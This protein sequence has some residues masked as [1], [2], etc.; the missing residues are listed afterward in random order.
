M[1]TA[2]RAIAIIMIAQAGI[3]PVVNFVLIRPVMTPP[4]FLINAATHAA[5][6]RLAA[7][8]WLSGATLSIA[9]AAVAVSV[10]RRF[11]D[12]MATWLVS[13]TVVGVVTTVA[14]AVCFL[15]MLSVSKQ[16]AQAGG[17]LDRY[18]PLAKALAS[19]RGWIHYGN[20]LLG[21]ATV[22]VFNIAL[23]RFSLVPRALS[24]FG[25]LAATLGAFGVVRPMLGYSLI[26]PL[27]TP[28]G[29]AQLALLLWLLVKGFSERPGVIPSE[30]RA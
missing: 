2:G 5:Q 13:V 24:A 22:A 8:L 14:E 26:L 18:L 4:G 10:I 7:M 19:A 25:V 27:L 9:L 23:L 1:K 20:L 28:L 30:A 15:T 12:P 29:L 6:M 3:A 17:S 16:Y 21:A 11:S